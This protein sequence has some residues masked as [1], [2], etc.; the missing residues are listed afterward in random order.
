MLE[1]QRV[2]W[3]ISVEDKG[4]KE[5]KQVSFSGGLTGVGEEGRRER[6]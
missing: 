5:Q 3:G 6:T 4:E 1:A 2:Y